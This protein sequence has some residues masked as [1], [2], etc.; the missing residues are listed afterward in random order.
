MGISTFNPYVS[1]YCS[2][3][4]KQEHWC[5][6]VCLF[7]YILLPFPIILFVSLIPAAFKYHRLPCLPICQKGINPPVRKSEFQPFDYFLIQPPPPLVATLLSGAVVRPVRARR[8]TDWALGFTDLAHFHYKVRRSRSLKIL[9][10]F[11]DMID[12]ER[13]HIQ[14]H[15]P[16]FILLLMLGFGSMERIVVR[17]R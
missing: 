10:R 7:C 14:V 13:V 17:I 16:T 1:I 6:F 11:Q 12:S 8:R 15:T 5:Q 4:G 9:E 2:G 3:E